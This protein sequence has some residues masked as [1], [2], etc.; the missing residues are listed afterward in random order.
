MTEQVITGK[1]EHEVR[2]ISDID[3]LRVAMKVEKNSRGY[4]FEAS[5]SGGK[6]VDEALAALKDAEAKLRAT[7]GGPAEA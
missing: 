1:I 6:T 5:V 3:S 4:N 2:H 7:W